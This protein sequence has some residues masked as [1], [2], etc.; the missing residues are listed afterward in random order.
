MSAHVRI[1]ELAEIL[2]GRSCPW[3]VLALLRAYFDESGVHG[4]ARVTGVAGFIGTAASWEYVEENWLAELSRFPPDQLSRF[5]TPQD[6]IRAFH[7]VDCEQGE[8][9]FWD[10]ARPI[11]EAFNVR[12]AHILAN[13]PEGLRVKGIWSAVETP[14]WSDFTTQEFRDRYAT[15][16]QLCAE[17]CFQQVANWSRTYAD[18]APVALVFAETGSLTKNIKEIFSYYQENKSWAHIKTF[19]TA[20]PVDCIPLQSADMLSYESYREWDG[21]FDKAGIEILQS[22]PALNILARANHLQFGGCFGDEGMRNAV[23]R[24]HR[25]EGLPEPYPLSA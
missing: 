11:R 7:A 2:H 8:G 12:L 23:N 6:A 14:S 10:I 20:S 3:R 19:A 22:K 15:P 13:A 5:R 25:A 1:S 18:S 16:Y 9:E 17:H 21:R 24:F 4:R